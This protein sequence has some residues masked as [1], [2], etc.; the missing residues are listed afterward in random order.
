MIKK[1]LIVEDD[2]HVLGYIEDTLCS[3]NHEHVWVTNQHDARQRFQDE[4][5]DYVLL[6]LQIPA[7]PNRGGAN[8]AYGVNLLREIMGKPP[9][10]DLPV[11]IMTAYTAEGLNLSNTLRSD[12]AADFIAK[13]FESSSRPLDKVIQEALDMCQGGSP[14]PHADAEPAQAGAITPFAGGNLLICA[15]HAELSGVKII[16]ARGQGRAL[17][18]LE[19]LARRDPQG[20]YA[21]QSGDEIAAAINAL[22]G[23]NAVTA[24]IQTLRRNITTRL[25]KVGIQCGPEDVIVHDEQGYYLRDWIVVG[26]PSPPQPSITVAAKTTNSRTGKRQAWVLDQLRAGRQLRRTDL[27]HEFSVQH[28]TAK[29]VLNDLVKD[30]LVEY[31]RQGQDGY[32]RLC[33]GSGGQARRTDGRGTA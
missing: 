16:S 32:Y 6:D 3:L 15:S 13:P 29:R 20:R 28:K 21:R 2:P 23:L 19:Q 4:Q 11:I 27:E 26:E 33:S 14:V 8:V 30:G 5:F 10:R 22:G 31:V 24:A 1:A 9:R 18:V 7:K 17:P 12:G 25:H